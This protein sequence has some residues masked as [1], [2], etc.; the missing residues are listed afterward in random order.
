VP[1]SHRGVRIAVLTLLAVDGVI[2]AV[3]GALFL[4]TYIGPVPLPVSALVS[5]VLNVALVWAA[6]HWTDSS[7]IAALPLWTWFGTVAALAFTGPGGDIVFANS[8]AT[9]YGLVLLFVLG[10]LPGVVVLMR[11]QRPRSLP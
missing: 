6:M 5:G 10:A 3:V 1:E 4:P 7:R 2:S 11:A 9:S 8:G